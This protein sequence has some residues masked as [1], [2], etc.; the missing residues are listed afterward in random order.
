MLLQRVVR[1]VKKEDLTNGE[2]GDRRRFFREVRLIIRK[3]SDQDVKRVEDTACKGTV[4][5][6]RGYL[7]IYSCSIYI[8]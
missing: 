8:I 6:R 2:K 3:A 7:L 5:I 4:V 1:S